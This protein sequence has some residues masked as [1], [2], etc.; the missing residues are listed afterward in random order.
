MTTVV[1]ANPR[2]AAGA[3]ARRWPRIER[4]LHDAIGPFELLWTSGPGGGEAC[5]V[6][7]LK[8]GADRVI[9]VGGDGT[10]SEVVA[11][12]FDGERLRSPG[13]AFGLLPLGTGGDLRRS[14][15]IP[16]HVGSA[17]RMLRNAVT[18]RIDVGRL[19]Y[20][21]HEGRQR[22][23]IF[24][25]IASFGIS[26]LVDRLAAESGKQLGG[27]V[28][29]LAA[30]ARAQLRYR[31]QRVRVSVD[32]GPA[33]EQ[34]IH[35]VAVANGRYFG[36]GM[37]I[38][39]GAEPDDGLFD[40]VTISRLSALELLRHGPKVY[41]GRH[42]GLPQVSVA[43]GVRVVAE[44]LPAEGDSDGAVLLD[45]DGEPLGRLPAELVMMPQ[46]LR[47]LVPAASGHDDAVGSGGGSAP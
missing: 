36:G 31:A 29:F 9:A 42:I 26:G 37:C 12:F 27:K 14:L 19:T 1:I 11:G 5:S 2:A 3:L 39:P 21:D 6:E 30:T 7:A 20:V 34:E 40:I 4:A 16:S 8:R 28:A 23:R 22:H 33:W 13:A 46:A 44:P 32:G 10:A 45:V 47:V 35:C 24:V 15:G 43:R 41:R 38:A 17:A 18:C 25:N